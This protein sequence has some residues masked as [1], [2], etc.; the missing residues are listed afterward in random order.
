MQ[1]LVKTNCFTFKI[2][3]DFMRAILFLGTS[4][5]G[6]QYVREAIEPLGF[7]PIFLLK[8]GEYSGIP[9]R[10]IEACEH[11]EADVNSLEDIL[12]AISEHGFMKDVVAITSLLDETLP[13]AC[14]IAQQ[15]KIIGPDPKLAELTDKAKVQSIIPEFSPPNLT[16]SAG[17]FTEDHLKQFLANCSAVD[18]FMLKP[19][20]S[21]GAVGTLVLNRS[22]I[23]IEQIKRLIT[24][25]KIDGATTYQNWVLQPRIMGR[26]HSLEGYVK[27]G[28]A[29]FLGFSRRVRK[30]LT[31]SVNE[32]PVDGEIPQELR[33]R[34]RQAVIELINRSGYRNG[35][36]HCEFIITAD[37]AYL[38]DGNM[39][40]V[41]GAAIVQQIA[42]VYG[43]NP[44]DIYRHVFDL[45]L[46]GGIHT[47]D[48][49]YHKVNN[50]P[51][52]SINYCLKEDAVVLSIAAPAGI[53]CHH[54][55]IADNG[56][57]IPAA[58]ESDSAWVGFLAGF[59][60]KVLEE[61]SRFIIQTD[62]G[63]VSPFFILSEQPSNSLLFKIGDA[64]TDAVQKI[65]NSTTKRLEM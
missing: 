43:K 53:T 10:A 22:S 59:R 7:R 42:L 28:Q 41:A 57:A 60:T 37:S 15:F 9:R 48:F 23:T 52:L 44:A 3:G 26:L 45:G 14:A 47:N 1:T 64:G 4:L 5:V 55:Q 40:R 62:K 56:K 39:G 19:G 36:F 31:E 30:A 54:T 16:F 11:H 34:C 12:R 25:S 46:F 17:K 24:E 21:S 29:S 61:I 18:E 2:N 6:A 38:I 8:V 63:P 65:E 27:D 20:I 50:E 49:S 33:D 35:Y 32:F 51:T 13:N 58:G